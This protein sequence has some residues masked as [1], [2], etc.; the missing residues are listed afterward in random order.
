MLPNFDQAQVLTDPFPHIRVP[1]ILTSQAADQVLRWLQTSAPWT[2]RVESF[3]EQ[4][5]FSLLSADLGQEVAHLVTPDFVDEIRRELLARF[6]IADDLALVD[7]GA[8]RLTSGQTIR[9]HND[10]LQEKETHRL[11]IQLNDGWGVDRGGLLLLFAG[12]EPE[13]LQSVV[14]PT[15]ASGFAFEIS[16]SSYH[17]V[18]SIREGERYTLVYTFR[19]QPRV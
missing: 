16:P 14:M 2:L 17:A 10:Y 18:S 7:I 11:L 13:S 8:H 19:R 3:Y 1:G 4:H 15:H 9:I 5:E 12:D 6:L